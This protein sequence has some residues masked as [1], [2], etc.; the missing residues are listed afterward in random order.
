LQYRIHDYFSYIHATMPVNPNSIPAIPKISGAMQQFLV[1]VVTEGIV[2]PENFEDCQQ[3]LKAYCE[4]ELLDYRVLV[5]NLHLFLGLVADFDQTKD[6]VLYYFLMLQASNCLF[7]EQAFALL[8]I[9]PPEETCPLDFN[10]L[11]ITT[12]AN[13]YGMV[14]GHLIGL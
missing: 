10:L 8:P 6:P 7:D 3:H 4:N 14:G 12:S 2:C 13:H 11:S 9:V 1:A 5:S